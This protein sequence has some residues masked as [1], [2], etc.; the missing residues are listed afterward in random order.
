MERA[1]DCLSTALHNRWH[2]GVP[3]VGI[4]FLV[5]SSSTASWQRRELWEEG[6]G[7]GGK[8]TMGRREN[9]GEEGRE[10]GRGKGGEGKGEDGGEDTEHRK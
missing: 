7:G 1:P 5:A 10:R 9:G 3:L 2:L 6:E 8:E 4:L